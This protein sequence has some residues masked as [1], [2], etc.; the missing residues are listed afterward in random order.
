[1]HMTQHAM[2]LLEEAS[3]R[4]ATAGNMGLSGPGGVPAPHFDRRNRPA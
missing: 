2:N 3:G 4:D 1:M